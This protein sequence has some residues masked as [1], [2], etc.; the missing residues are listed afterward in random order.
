MG[1]FPPGPPRIL[2]LLRGFRL[3]SAG[4]VGSSQGQQVGKDL[5]LNRYEFSPSRPSA[6]S[7]TEVSRNQALQDP[8]APLR[9]RQQLLHDRCH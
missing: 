2:G 8:D 6:S 5:D 1:Q 7:A 4:T 9:L 3:S